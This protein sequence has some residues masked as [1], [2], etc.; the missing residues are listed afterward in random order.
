MQ[1]PTSPG[2]T[3]TPKQPP[4]PPIG[5]KQSSQPDSKTIPPIPKTTT[6]PVLRSVVLKM[7]QVVKE[8][9]G[10]ALHTDVYDG[11]AVAVQWMSAEVWLKCRIVGRLC[12]NVIHRFG[13]QC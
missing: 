3:S 9:K 13:C 8:D 4:L 6:L 11:R 7:G 5:K 2:S 12:I 1:R 10:I